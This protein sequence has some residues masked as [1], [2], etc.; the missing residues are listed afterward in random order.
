MFL[1]KPSLAI[2]AAALLLAPL[3]TSLA[4]EPALEVLRRLGDHEKT[5]VSMLVA[6]ELGAASVED[7]GPIGAVP[8]AG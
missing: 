2:A 5:H 4:A 7:A 8:R 6:A 1:L 3:S